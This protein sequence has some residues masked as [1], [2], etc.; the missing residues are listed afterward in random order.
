MVSM[1]ISKF[2]SGPLST[3]AILFGCEETGI[4]AVIDPSQGST[5]LLLQEAHRLGL[6]IKFIFLTHS[7]WDHIADV[8][9]LREKTGAQVYIHPLDEGNLIEPGSDG[10]DLYFPIR[11]VEPDWSL[12][13][14][15]VVQVGQLQVEVIHTP[16]H[17]PGCVC[18]YIKE[19]KVLFSGDTLFKGTIGGLHLPTAREPL[20]WGSLDKLALLPSDVRVISGHGDDT[21]IGQESWLQ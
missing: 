4:G 1:I 19:A 12:E 21:T 8:H 15:K 6:Q 7:H 9:E 20:M 18:L 5:R 14:G 2:P 10:L 13:E 11:G 3:N 17:S 16:G